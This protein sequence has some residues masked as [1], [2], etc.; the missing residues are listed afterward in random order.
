[1]DPLAHSLVGATLAESGLRRVSPLATAT[2]VLGANAPDI[3]ALAGLAGSDAALYW[4]RG[5]T[6]GVVAMAVLPLVLTGVMLA[7]DR[8]VRRRREPAANPARAWPLVGLALLSTLTHP[9]L[10]WLNSYGVRLLMPFDAGWHYGD[11]LFILDP[12]LWLLAGASVVLARTRGRPSGAAFILLGCA[13]T[14]LM[15]L[16][17]L[18]PM[19]ARVL[20]LLGVTVIVALRFWLP[21]MRHIPRIA[22]GCGVCMLL[23]VAAMVHG[24]Q[25]AR[26]DA[27]A[28]LAER[29]IHPVVVAASLLP[30]DPFVRELIARAGDH[31]YFVERRWV[32]RPALRFSHAPIALGPDDAVTRAA[33]AQPAVRG[34]SNWLR[35]PSLEVH[36]HDHGYAVSIRDVRYSRGRSGL[37]SAVVRLDHA[38]RPLGPPPEPL[39]QP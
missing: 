35:L 5:I 37:G 24:S 30:A 25:L 7:W 34:L 3:D 39:P 20:W 38:L 17:G 23:Y 4:R 11:A 29:G 22:S 15:T 12:W 1:M 32:G 33:L 31:Y 9:A 16:N 8:W 6:H 27:R 18:V 26:A 10:D 2:L 13:L 28:W 14:V 21:A 19:F 36:A